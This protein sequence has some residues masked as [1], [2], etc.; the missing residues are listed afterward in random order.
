MLGKLWDYIA[1]SFVDL[2][3]GSI[4]SPVCQPALYSDW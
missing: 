4:F 1:T 2:H 3:R